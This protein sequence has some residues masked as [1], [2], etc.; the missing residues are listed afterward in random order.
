MVPVAVG[1]VLAG[2]DRVAGE[3]VPG[4]A[5]EGDGLAHAE[6]GVDHV[7]VLEGRGVRAVLQLICWNRHTES[8]A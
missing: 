5:L 6:V 1:P 3:D 8:S 2:E 7:P 4:V